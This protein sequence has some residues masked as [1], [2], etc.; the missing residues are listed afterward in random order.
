MTNAVTEAP[1][2]IVELNMTE[3]QWKMWAS[4][5]KFPAFIGGL[6][7]GKTK[8]MIDCAIRD[9]LS[10]DD[11]LIALYEP[12]YDLVRLI[13]APRLQGSLDEYG[14]R[15]KYN[16][17][18]NYISV[19]SPQC[20]DFVLRTLEN[21]ARIIGYESYRAHVDE[22]DTLKRANAQLCWNKIIARNRQKPTT[23]EK[24]Q[25]RVSVYSTPEGFGFVYH[26]WAKNPKPSYWMVQ[27]ATYSNPYLPDDYIDGLK[28]SYPEQ[29]VSAYVEGQ[30]V[31]LTSGSVYPSFN[32]VLNHTA[33]TI[34]P[35]EPVHI[36]MDFNVLNMTAEISTIRNGLPLTLEELTQIRDTPSMAATIKER[37]VDRGHPVIVYP[38]ASGGNTSSKKWSESDISILRQMGLTIRVENSNP[39]VKDRVNAVNA[40]ILNQKGDRRWLVNTDQCPKLTEA[41][42]QQVY[43]ANGQP[44]KTSGNDHPNDA[45]GY[46]LTNRYP[47]AKRTTVVQP[48]RG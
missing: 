25:N 14:I 3:P 41:L 35:F 39:A 23:I 30:F 10:A 15:Y 12:T 21:P 6:G 32:R 46:F 24:A 26:H 34:K 17:V 40:M 38:D 33:E 47:V 27:A 4:T 18:E 48:L 37:Y 8:T 9:A 29:L 2:R 28:E 20:G 31:N 11:S 7:S 5:A 45:V 19:S 43:D 1:S 13:L 16:K 44:D 36:G 22:I 42:E